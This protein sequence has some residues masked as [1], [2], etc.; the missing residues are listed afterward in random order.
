MSGQPRTVDVYGQASR[1]LG[2]PRAIEYQVFSQ[3]TAELQQAQRQGDFPRLAEALGRNGKLWAALIADLS[4][5]DNAL[6]EALRAQL[7]SLGTF[8]LRH[9]RL[10]LR[11][12]AEAQPILDVNLAVMRGLRGAVAA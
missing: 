5:S 3:V 4:R 7:I 11:R 10:V 9:T 1:A 6:P 12:E 2:T 8:V